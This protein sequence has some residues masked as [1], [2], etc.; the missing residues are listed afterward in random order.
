MNEQN[1]VLAALRAQTEATHLLVTALQEKTKA[2]QE[3]ATA[4]NRLVDYL[5][6]SD[7]EGAE[8]VAASTYLSGS[9]R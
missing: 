2:D 7:G 8:P 5:C 3:N 4:V 9:P 6:A 1:E